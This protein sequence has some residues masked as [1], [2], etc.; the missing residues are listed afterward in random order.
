MGDLD[1]GKGLGR[2]R[3]TCTLA[4]NRCKPIVTTMCRRSAEQDTTGGP[5]HTESTTDPGIFR[6][7]SE[8]E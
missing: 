4:Y 6:L 2:N 3:T 1:S 8:S 5:R 7:D